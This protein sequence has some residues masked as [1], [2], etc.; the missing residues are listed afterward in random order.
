MFT[1]FYSCVV[2]GSFFFATSSTNIDFT[3]PGSHENYRIGDVVRF[4][5]YYMGFAKRELDS[6]IQLNKFH[7]TTFPDSIASAYIQNATF[8][9]DWTAFHDIIKIRIFFHQKM[10]IQIIMIRMIKIKPMMNKKKGRKKR[11][12]MALMETMI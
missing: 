10:K 2:L 11:I 6:R 5:D 9:D 12:K 4:Q 1:T 7:L 8:S 3:Q